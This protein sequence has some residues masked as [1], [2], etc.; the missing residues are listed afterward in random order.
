M[1]SIKTTIVGCILIITGI[2]MYIKTG[3]FEQPGICITM[4]VGFLFAKDHDVTGT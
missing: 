3:E 4:G 2:V 1:K